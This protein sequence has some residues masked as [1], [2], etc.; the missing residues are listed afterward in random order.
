MKS[1]RKRHWHQFSLRTLLLLVAAA[2]LVLGL[3]IRPLRQAWIRRKVVELAENPD[4]Q[5]I[6]FLE[7]AIQNEDWEVRHLAGLALQGIGPQAIPPLVRVIE[8]EGEPARTRAA[9]VFARLARSNRIG[10][11]AIPALEDALRNDD[12][13]VR[14]P[15]I[16]GFGRIGGKA[17]PA[18]ERALEDQDREVR[19][20][21]VR[22]LEL[23]G[24]E[25]KPALEKAL[26]DK[27]VGVCHAAA[28][29]LG[30]M[31][32]EAVPALE[33]ALSDENVYVRYAATRGL[34]FVGPEAIPALEQ[35]L[36]DEHDAVRS[37]AVS[38]LGQIGPQAIPALEQARTDEDEVVRDKAE[39]HLEREVLAASI[40]RGF[41]TA[42]LALT[43]EYRGHAFEA[44]LESGGL[45][46]FDGRRYWAPSQA[47]R[48][49]VATVTGERVP[50]SGWE[51]WHYQD[52]QGKRVSLETARQAFLSK[53]DKN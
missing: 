6:P 48:E 5:A 21:A 16:G 47:A 20:A 32:P 51:F 23:I 45:V 44:Q 26:R 25:A 30:E 8:E 3:A 36:M 14:H 33:E 49:A 43:A 24:P 2:A 31:G 50:T 18:L 13:R 22:A 9:L 35:A 15:A 34:G 4:P 46:T 42:P 10:V 53:D 11:E 28:V 17:I 27:D 40:R 38:G 29:A 52:A 41:L 7:E 1:E 39:A 37:G 19:Y 12:D